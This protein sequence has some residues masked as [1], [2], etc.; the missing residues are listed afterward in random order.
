MAKPGS[1]NTYPE[2][3]KG[4]P[5]SVRGQTAAVC[6]QLPQQTD[7]TLTR[8]GYNCNKNAQAKSTRGCG[9]LT[10]FHIPNI[11]EAEKRRHVA[12]HIQSKTLKQ[13]CATREVQANK[14]TACSRLF[15]A[16]RLDGETRHSSGLFSSAGCLSSQNIPPTVVQRPTNA[17]DM[18][19]LRA[20][21]SAKVLCDHNKLD[22]RTPPQ[23]GYSCPHIPRRLF[24]SSPRLPTLKGT[25]QL[26]YSYLKEP[27]MDTKS[28][29][30][31]YDT[32]KIRGVPRRHMGPLEKRD[33]S[34]PKVNMQIEK[35]RHKAPAQKESKSGR[36]TKC[37]RNS[38]FR[39]FCCSQG[40]PELSPFTGAI[41]P[42]PE[43]KLSKAFTSFERNHEGARLVASAPQETI[44]NTHT[45]PR[46]SF[47][48]RC[49]RYRLGR[50]AGQPTALR[51]MDFG[52]TAFTFQPEG[53]DRNNQS[54]WRSLSAP[55][56]HSASYSKRQPNSGFIYSE[57]RRNQVQAINGLD[58]PGV[59]HPGPVQ[60][61]CVDLSHSRSIQLSRRQ[62][63]STENNTR[64]ASPARDYTG[65]ICKMGDTHGGSVCFGTSPC[66]GH[67]R[68]SRQ[69][70]RKGEHTRCT[71]HQLEF[72]PSLD[73]PSTLSNTQDI[74]APQSSPGSLSCGS[75]TLGESV[76]ETRSETTVPISPI[77]LK[78]SRA[79]SN[80]R[81]HGSSS[82]ECE[83]DDSRNMAMWGWNKHLTN[84]TESQKLLL[85]A[86]WRPSTLKTYRPAW[87]RWI[88]WTQQN[89]VDKYKPSGSDLARFLADLHQKE[90]LALNTILVHKSVVSTFCDPNNRY[91]LS[92]HILVKQVL[93]AIS[94]AKPKPLKPP[95][96]DI[97]VFTNHLATKN[98]D[99]NSLYEASCHTASIL[100]LCS[101][102]RIHDLTLLK[103]SPEHCVISDQYIILKPS[104]GSKTDSV[105]HRQSSWK[106]IKNA[107]SKSLD[108][109]HWIR[110]LIH[111]SKQR[112]IS[113]AT[114]ECL[115]VTTAGQAKPASSAVI[116]GWVKRLLKE[117]KIDASP[118]SCRSA[119]ASKNWLENFSLHDILARG[120]WKSA[121]TFTKFYQREI[122]P[123]SE[124]Q[125]ETLI[126]TLFAPID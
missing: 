116:S 54:T 121:N 72:Q 41:K 98:P 12:T 70:G 30:V 33:V 29:K 59:Y 100:L 126:T 93:K 73:I 84:W 10:Q 71:E 16:L 31:Y 43:I 109:V 125:R 101:G 37:S 44:E 103:I 45:C 19:A 118:G 69:T 24:L 28:R 68:N 15:T 76:L 105:T 85:A 62:V 80:R 13:I 99:T 123:A 91:E 4:L 20:Q 35:A 3:D 65:S 48:H 86:S 82:P 11:L 38:K 1:T 17:N 58:T 46:A 39:Q 67:V 104:Y 92:S 21:F 14:R 61:S 36:I 27:R 97:D 115:F 95:I 2:H 9:S 50:N 51:P 8:D 32:Q 23:S 106:L 42:R 25:C 52:G 112:R 88:R 96:W 53:N 34:P 87:N 47:S 64:V 66:G 22:R 55:E 75:P 110:L 77:H 7:T 120:N 74:G 5:Y 117:A 60:Y 107:S 78:E 102:R 6:S 122:D 49:E 40:T 63:V 26:G 83:R 108:P 113:T 79:G 119:V 56:I 114:S 18:L 90:K 94:S 124:N 111:L 89:K 57:R 81:I